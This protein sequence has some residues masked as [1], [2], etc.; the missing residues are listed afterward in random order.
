MVPSL[1]QSCTIQLFAYLVIPGYRS[2][3]CP[4]L[5]VNHRGPHPFRLR[6]SLC[7]SLVSWPCMH[8]FCHS[9]LSKAGLEMRDR[10]YF[11]AILKSCIH[12]SKHVSTRRRISYTQEAMMKKTLSF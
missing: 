11:G 5:L 1:I 9:G 7:F 3:H 8:S 10:I 2:V 12:G 4:G 6:H